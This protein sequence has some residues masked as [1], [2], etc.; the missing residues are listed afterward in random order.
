MSE[1]TAAVYLSADDGG[2]SFMLSDPA[3]LQQRSMILARDNGD[4]IMVDRQ[5]FMDAGYSVTVDKPAPAKRRRFGRK[6]RGR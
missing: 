3:Q 5:K 2:E 1:T 6:G 4:L